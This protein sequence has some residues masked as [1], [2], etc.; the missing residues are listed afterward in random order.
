MGAKYTRQSGAALC[1]G[2]AAGAADRGSLV[3]SAP[4]CQPPSVGK[5]ANEQQQQPRS[6]AI[7][8]E[9]YNDRPRERTT[10][11]KMPLHAC[12]Q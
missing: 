7:T 6:M 9:A 10:V 8:L 1:C 12:N 11:M 4:E 2:A 5:P 3:P